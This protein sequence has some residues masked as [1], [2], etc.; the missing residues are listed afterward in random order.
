MNLSSY[1][2]LILIKLTIFAVNIIAVALRLHCGS[3]KLIFDIIPLYFAK[4]KNFV[5]TCSLEPGD[6]SSYSASLHS[7]NYMQRSYISQNTLKRCVAVAVRLCLFFQFTSNKFCNPAF[8]SDKLPKSL[9][10]TCRSI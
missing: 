10:Y 9:N 8:F 2:V 1:T 3:C 5:H 7:P 6:T 4:F